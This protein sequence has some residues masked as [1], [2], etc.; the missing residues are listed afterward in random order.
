M[1]W[2]YNIDSVDGEE[3]LK[4]I[5]LRRLILLSSLLFFSVHIFSIGNLT[6]IELQFIIKYIFSI[7]IE[8]GVLWHKY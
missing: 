4:I 8:R 6:N 2:L 1:G 3:Y 5:R 7:G